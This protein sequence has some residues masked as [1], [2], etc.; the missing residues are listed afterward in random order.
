MKKDYLFVLAAKVDCN[1]EFGDAVNLYFTKITKENLEEIR[2]WIR[3]TRQLKKE[4]NNF[5]YMKYGS[6]G[7]FCSSSEWEQVLNNA[8]DDFVLLEEY[9]K[10]VKEEYGMRGHTITIYADGD[11]CFSAY[12]KNSSEDYGTPLLF[13]EK[14]VLKAKILNDQEVQGLLKNET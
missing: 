1:N 3:K 6:D 2:L 14:R 12:Q 5:D 10:N 11:I 7:E 9:P 8:G 4:N 13:F